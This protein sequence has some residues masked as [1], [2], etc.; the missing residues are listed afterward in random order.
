[1][2]FNYFILLHDE[3]PQLNLSAAD[4]SRHFAIGS[5]ENEQGILPDILFCGSA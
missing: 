4:S 5:V 3:I 2:K 1:M